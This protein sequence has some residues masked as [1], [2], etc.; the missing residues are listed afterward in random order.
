MNKGMT[1]EEADY[2]RNSI[3][4]IRKEYWMERGYSEEDAE[5]K[6]KECKRSNEG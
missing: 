2:K 6:A 5:K 3:R 1:E 4:P